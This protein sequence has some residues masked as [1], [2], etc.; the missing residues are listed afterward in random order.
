M[1]QLSMNDLAAEVHA[2]IEDVEGMPSLK[3][4]GVYEILQA[5]FDVAAKAIAAGEDISIPHFGKFKLRIQNARTGRNPAT[6]KALKIPEKSVV[7]FQ[8]STHLRESAAEA[9]SVVKKNA[10]AKAAHKAKGKSKAKGKK[11]KK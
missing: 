1:G 9:H 8:P 3:R 7:K 6:G 10:K 5:T 4:H 2:R 11:K